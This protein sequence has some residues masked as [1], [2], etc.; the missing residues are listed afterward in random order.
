MP[1]VLL[2]S[3]RYWHVRGWRAPRLAGCHMALTNFVKFS[4]LVRKLKKG[5]HVGARTRTRTQTYRHTQTHTHTHTHTHIRY[6]LSGL[7][8][9]NFHDSNLAI[10]QFR[11]LPALNNLCPVNVDVY[12]RSSEYQKLFLGFLRGKNI[13]KQWRNQLFSCVR[14]FTST[15][16]ILLLVTCTVRVFVCCLPSLFLLVFLITHRTLPS[17]AKYLWCSA[18]RVPQSGCP[19]SASQF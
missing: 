14:L 19:K 17:T 3:V 8:Q 16:L 5:Q 6:Y 18:F 15:V 11:P 10:S 9:I 1:A 4:H 12:G 2:L 13:G 7:L